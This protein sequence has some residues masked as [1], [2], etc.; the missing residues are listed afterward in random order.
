MVDCVGTN[1]CCLDTAARSIAYIWKPHG[2]IRYHVYVHS[3]SW[4]SCDLWA[5]WYTRKDLQASGTSMSAITALKGSDGRTRHPNTIS[6]SPNL[7]LMSQDNCKLCLVTETQKMYTLNNISFS[8]II[9]ISFEINLQIMI[10]ITNLRFLLFWNCAIVQI[11][12]LLLFQVLNVWAMWLLISCIFFIS[13]I[14]RQKCNYF[15]CLGMI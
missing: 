9:I 7:L 14:K 6:T 2:T 10:P 4:Q 11:I 3:T 5:L 15:R 13:A 12:Y 8:L 1:D